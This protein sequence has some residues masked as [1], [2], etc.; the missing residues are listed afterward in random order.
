MFEI[1]KEKR[2][3]SNQKQPENIDSTLTPDG[4]LYRCTHKI[5]IA[6]GQD[7]LIH[8]NRNVDKVLLFSITSIKVKVSF[9]L[10]A[11]QITIHFTL[12]QTVQRKWSITINNNHT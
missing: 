5:Q 8:L 6:T 11:L 2:T 3:C 10:L 9:V 1:N 7:I 12:R 4:H